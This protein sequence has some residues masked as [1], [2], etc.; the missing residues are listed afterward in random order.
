MIEQ[1]NSVNNYTG[2]TSINHQTLLSAQLDAMRERMNQMHQMLL[3][4]PQQQQQQAHQH[5]YGWNPYMM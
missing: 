2:V 5:P 1:A 3:A 4:P